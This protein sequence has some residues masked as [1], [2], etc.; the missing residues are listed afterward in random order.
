[1]GIFLLPMTPG[2]LPGPP[3]LYFVMSEEKFMLCVYIFVSLPL[4][5]S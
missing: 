4:N 2:G 3:W 5:V 1:M